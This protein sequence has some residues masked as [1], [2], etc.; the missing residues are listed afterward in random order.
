MFSR[1]QQELTKED[2]QYILGEDLDDFEK[3]ITPR[4]YCGHCETNYLS[5]IINYKIFLNDLNDVI[6]QGFCKKCGSPM[7][8]YIETGEVDK[9]QERIK[10]TRSRIS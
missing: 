9:Y 8:R 2:L 6:L 1:K 5:I 10:K 7:G 4:C 3:I